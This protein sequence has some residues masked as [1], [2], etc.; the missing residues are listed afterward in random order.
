MKLAF[1]PFTNAEVTAMIVN[2]IRLRVCRLIYTY[3]QAWFNGQW[4]SRYDQSCIIATFDL[5]VPAGWIH[6]RAAIGELDAS[7]LLD[8]T[9]EDTVAL[10]IVDM[11]FAGWSWFY[12]GKM[13]TP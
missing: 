7:M 10:S 9:V 6:G 2:S 12:R 3:S 11:R 13:C 8:H 4:Q 5:G 1:K